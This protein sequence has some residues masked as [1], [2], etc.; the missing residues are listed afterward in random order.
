LF[1]KNASQGTKWLYFLKIW[2]GMALLAPLATPMMVSHQKRHQR[3]YVTNQLKDNFMY[4]M[5]Y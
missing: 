4:F 5:E 3:I 2:G 1:G